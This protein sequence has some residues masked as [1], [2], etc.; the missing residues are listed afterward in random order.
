MNLWPNT[1]LEPTAVGAFTLTM[2]DN[3]TSQD[4]ITR[5]CAA[6]AQLGR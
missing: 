1:S 4:S 6:M 2:I 3:F 5:R